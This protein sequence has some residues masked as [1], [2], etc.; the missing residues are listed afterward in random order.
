M[1]HDAAAYAD[2]LDALT[3]LRRF[4]ERPDRKR[5]FL[6]ELGV[7][8]ELAVLRTLAAVDR[9]NAA[10]ARTDGAAHTTVGAVGEALAVNQSTASRLVEQAVRAGYLDRHADAADGRRT[11]LALT[12]TGRSLLARADVIRRGWLSAVTEDWEAAEV[13]SLVELLRR[14][15]D[16]AARVEERWR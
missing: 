15:L 14:F 4:W 13:R 6:A 12:A 3:D 5:W 1:S 10:C 2:L 7:P 9:G 8:V 11:G 16:D